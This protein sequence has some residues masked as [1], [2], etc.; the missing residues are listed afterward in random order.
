MRIVGPQVR[1]PRRSLRPC[2][3]GERSKPNDLMAL[4]EVG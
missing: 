2:P 4:Y 1:Q 3:L